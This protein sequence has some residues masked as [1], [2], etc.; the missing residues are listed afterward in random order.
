MD[1]AFIS[2]ALCVAT[3]T[4]ISYLL[5]RRLEKKMASTSAQVLELLNTAASRLSNVLD[6]FKKIIANQPPPVQE[7]LQPL[8]DKVQ[9]IIDALNAADPDNTDN[10]TP[11]TPNSGEPL[12][13]E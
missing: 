6:D 12:P 11:A 4:L 9:G 8:A 13:G 10:E 3:S 7:D 2:Y 5:Y 1:H